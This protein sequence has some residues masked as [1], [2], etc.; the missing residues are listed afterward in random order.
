MS[1]GMG[2]GDIHMKTGGWGGGVGNGKVRGWTG[3]EGI[4]YGV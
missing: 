3:V 4:K 1:G 2:I